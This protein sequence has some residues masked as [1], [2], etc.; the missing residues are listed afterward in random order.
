MATRLRKTFTEKK[1]DQAAVYLQTAFDPYLSFLCPS[2]IICQQGL[3]SGSLNCDRFFWP[4]AIFIPGWLV[5]LSVSFP[6]KTW[7][8]IS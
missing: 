3:S 2:R 5:P 1:P 4:P 6:E 8:I 7:K